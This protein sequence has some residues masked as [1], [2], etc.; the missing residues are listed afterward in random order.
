M[1]KC[2]VTVPVLNH[3]DVQPFDFESMQNTGTASGQ[4]TGTASVQNSGTP[5]GLFVKVTVA[6]VRDDPLPQVPVILPKLS[7]TPNRIFTTLYLPPTFITHNY[8]I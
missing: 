3:E 7:L 8:P 4:N 5:T 6:L 2:D 1:T